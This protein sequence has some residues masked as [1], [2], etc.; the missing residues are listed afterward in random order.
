VWAEEAGSAIV[1]DNGFTLSDFRRRA[2]IRGLAPG[3]IAGILLTHEHVDH[4]RGVGHLS[5]A[6]RCAVYSSPDTLEAAV[7]REERPYHAAM[8]L[9][10][11]NPMRIGPFEVTALAGSHDSVDCQIYVLRTGGASLGIAT[12]LGVVPEAVLREFEGLSA[13]VLEFN[14]DPDMLDR[15]RYPIF[16]KRRIRGPRGHLSNWEGAEFLS[17]INHPGL[18]CVVLGH[19]SRNNNRPELALAAARTAVTGGPGDPRIEVASHD[20]PTPIIEI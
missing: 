6:C 5:R 8:K 4:Q 3:R 7:S 18:K 17:R 9:V 16:L 13:A 1:V 14:H 19:I 11:G 15:G 10:P 2:A 20:V 12:D